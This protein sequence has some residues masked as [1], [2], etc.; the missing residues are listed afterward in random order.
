MVKFAVLGKGLEKDIVEMV[1]RYLRP[2]QEMKIMLICS[3]LDIPN[4]AITDK[5]LELCEVLES[6]YHLNGSILHRNAEGIWKTKHPRWDQK[7]FSFLF[8]S[9][10]TTT[11]L[12]HRKNLNDSLVAI[13][14]IREEAVAYSAIMTLYDMVRQ[15]FV[16]IKLFEVVFKE[17]ISHKPLI[18]SN[19]KV[20]SVFVW[21]SEAYKALGDFQDG[22][23]NSIEALSW[24]SDNSM[25]H[26]NKGIALTNLG[27][28]EEALECFDK[29]LDIDRGRPWA[30]MYLV[31]Q[32]RSLDC[33]GRHEEA[34]AC[35]DKV[36]EID[37]N[38]RDAYATL[39]VCFAMMGKD[40]KVIICCDKALKYVR[41][42][43][44]LF[45]KLYGD[46]P[47]YFPKLLDE[48]VLCMIHSLK[49]TALLRV[50][51]SD[52]A[53]SC[54][55]K[56]LEIKP[57]DTYALYKK[58]EVLAQLKKYREAMDVFQ[59]LL[60]IDSRDRN[61]WIRIG[62]LHYNLGEYSEA[63]NC[64]DHVLKI[65]LNLGDVWYFKGQAL[66]AIDRINAQYC[67]DKAKDLGFI[68]TY[69][70]WKQEY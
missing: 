20:S 27:R 55:D 41:L 31:A 65:D 26:M 57:D 42:Y 46:I 33:L 36:L 38:D 53:M 4:L 45:L 19:E 18:L 1:D 6:A 9:N 54:F 30:W 49:G 62:T 3:L 70:Y 16:P 59:R 66:L 58:G 34:V 22:L 50:G 52:E 68:Y 63:V 14:R 11:L 48:D 10:N 43:T 17:S 61:V 28:N 29:A 7:L 21:I 35:F 40:E 60:N 44:A 37:P 12:Q 13:Y 23:D 47:H 51:N 67:F 25:A 24:D 64:Y 5:M 2:Q 15:N 69:Q 56:V 32:G 8:G 39:G